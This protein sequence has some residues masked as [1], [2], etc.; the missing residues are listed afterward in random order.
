MIRY[1]KSKISTTEWVTQNQYQ[2]LK[3][4]CSASALLSTRSPDIYKTSKH[5]QD[6]VYNNLMGNAVTIDL[7]VGDWI[8]TGRFKN[9]REM[10]R[11]IGVDSKGQPTV[12]GK[13]ML[14]FRIEKAMPQ[15]RQ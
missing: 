1:S 3:M 10:V 12:N 9:K 14:K 13:P 2:I 6:L 15:E 11:T 5:Y 7:K 4:N 8:L